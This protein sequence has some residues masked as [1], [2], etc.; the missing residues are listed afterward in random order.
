VGE[1]KAT[2]DKYPSIG[3]LLP[4][5]GYSPKQIKDM[6]TTINKVPCEVV[7]SGTPIALAK[8][9]KVNKPLVTVGYNLKERKG[10]LTVAEV[11]KGFLKKYC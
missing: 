8:L 3:T 1:I 9:V 11:V 2:Y 5:M 4:A 10:S 7:V 6:E